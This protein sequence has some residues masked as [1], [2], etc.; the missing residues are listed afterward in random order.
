M[1]KS[2]RARERRKAT[3]DAQA[4]ADRRRAWLTFGIVGLPAIA[5]V[6]LVIVAVVERGG[7]ATNDPAASLT[8]VETYDV[9][10][11]EHVQEPVAYPQQP[12]VGGAHAPVWQNCG[13]YAEAVPS[14]TAVHSMEHGAVWIT[15]DPA[16]PADEI[17]A[18]EELSGRQSFVLASP[19]DGLGAP[20]VASAWGRQLEL[21]GP[22]D[23]QLAL[24]IRAFRTGPQTPE[25]G[26]PCTGGF[27][28]PAS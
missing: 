6:I 18:L 9:S 7:Q 26:A 19:F 2:Q 22:D 8:G 16:L 5:T 25:P 20:V 10:T 27:G 11:R 13:F 3:A 15:Y 28:E 23:P 4:D 14:E 24:F 12:P 17:A 1:S 21:T